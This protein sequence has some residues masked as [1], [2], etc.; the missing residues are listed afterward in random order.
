[1][2]ARPSPLAQ[3]IRNE[4]RRPP[5]AEPG[6]RTPAR[7]AYD[8]R[9]L[10]GKGSC[11]A[12]ASLAEKLVRWL[13]VT[14]ISRRTAALA[15]CARSP[16]TYATPRWVSRHERATGHSWHATSRR[17]GRNVTTWIALYIEIKRVPFPRRH[18]LPPRAA[19]QQALRNYQFIQRHA[20]RFVFWQHPRWTRIGC[21]GENLLRASRTRR[22]RAAPVVPRTSA[23]LRPGQR[24][25][26]YS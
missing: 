6:V 14:E 13:S 16:S 24:R 11:D 22:H 26:P 1:L 23:F 17:V 21:Q 2:G 12:T 3:R 7:L 8:L 15:S 25:P 4:P 10:P 9:K 5:A 20:P 18:A 19:R